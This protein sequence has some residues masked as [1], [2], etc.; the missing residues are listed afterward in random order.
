MVRAAAAHASRQLPGKLFRDSRTV[1]MLDTC[2][3]EV[4]TVS[5]K[6]PQMLRMVL[7]CDVIIAVLCS[8]CCISRLHSL[9]G[10]KPDAHR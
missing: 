2:S 7:E 4:R 6:K 9:D 10:R 3:G 1:H 5:R 8:C